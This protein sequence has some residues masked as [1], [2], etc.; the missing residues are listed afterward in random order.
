MILLLAL[1]VALFAPVFAC[2]AVIM[3]FGCGDRA[4]DPG[5]GGGGEGGAGRRLPGPFS[6]PGMPRRLVPARRDDLARSA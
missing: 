1:N 5:G 3:W 2:F 4:D 6:G